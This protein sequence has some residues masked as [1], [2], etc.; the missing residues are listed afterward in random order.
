MF[1]LFIYLCVCV[2]LLFLG[3]GFFEGRVG[4]GGGGG[5]LQKIWFMFTFEKHLLLHFAHF[6]KIYVWLWDQN[7]LYSCHC[8]KQC[9]TR[10]HYGLH[11]VLQDR[12]F[13]TV[14]AHDNSTFHKCQIT[15]CSIN[16]DRQNLTKNMQ[17]CQMGIFFSFYVLPSTLK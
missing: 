14:R 13:Y 11:A 8:I 16:G 2:L 3:V 4:G 5:H 10:A 17:T 6:S 7:T 1:L 15:A 9:Q 12:V